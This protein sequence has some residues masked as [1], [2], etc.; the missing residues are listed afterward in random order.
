M[1]LGLV[2]LCSRTGN[3]EGG[4]CRYEVKAASFA[5]A[6]MWG[7]NYRQTSD[8]TTGVSERRANEEEVCHGDDQLV[9]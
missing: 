2:L 7:C 5:F 1:G 8:D 6:D 4:G 9:E 3:G